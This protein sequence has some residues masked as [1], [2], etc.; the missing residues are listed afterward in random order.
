MITDEDVEVLGSDP[1]ESTKSNHCQ[2]ATG[3][4]STHGAFSDQAVMCHIRNRE[5]CLALAVAPVASTTY[6][7]G[8][9]SGLPVGRSAE[10][11]RAD[12][13]SRAACLPRRRA[14]S[15]RAF[16]PA[17]FR[18]RDPSP[19]V[20][21][22]DPAPRFWSGP[23]GSALSIVGA[24]P[25]LCS[26]VLPSCCNSERRANVVSSYHPPAPSRRLEQDVGDVNLAC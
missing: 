20:A 22:L 23:R 14:S 6:R 4:P 2:V 10:S 25:P 24:G 5:K 21:I 15:R 8:A 12:S 7:H 17:T 16:T 26:R 18:F 13:T 1:D 9:R 19:D 11:H 3:N